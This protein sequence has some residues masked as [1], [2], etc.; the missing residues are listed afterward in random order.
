MAY[1]TAEARQ[2]L[3]DDLAMSIEELGVALAALGA[4][5]E[6]LDEQS[7]DRLEE[8][9]FRPVQSAYGRAQRTHSAFAERYGLPTRSFAPASAGLPSQ[10]VKGFLEKA[11]EAIAEAD[12]LL[13]ELQDSMAPVEVGDEQL[14]A[15][16]SE[17]RA[18]LADLQ[19]RATLFVSRFGR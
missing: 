9:L 1:V 3:L 16:L 11:S 18:L 13:A 8:R 6:A 4:A 7:G 2:N 19:D 5:Y 10:G 17:V 15:G 14:R 12:T